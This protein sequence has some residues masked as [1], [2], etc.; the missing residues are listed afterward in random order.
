M[1]REKEKKDRDREYRKIIERMNDYP[2]VA[3][4][5]NLYEEL[6]KVDYPDYI[7]FQY[8]THVSDSTTT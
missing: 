3:D 7:E 6:P 5:L 2:G 1:K 8:I 4:L